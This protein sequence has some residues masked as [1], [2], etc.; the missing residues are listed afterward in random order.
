MRVRLDRSVVAP[1]ATDLFIDSVVFVLCVWLFVVVCVGCVC[2]I[3][4]VFF[5]FFFFFVFFFFF[6]FNILSIFILY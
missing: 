3:F 6:F 2:S 1:L 4:F 5:F